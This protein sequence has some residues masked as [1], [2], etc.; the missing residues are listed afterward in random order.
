MMA[1]NHS[2]LVF[3]LVFG[4]AGSVSADEFHWTNN[5]TDSNSWCNRFNWDPNAN[6][7]GTSDTAV[8][9]NPHRGPIVDCDAAVGSI[10]GPS[11]NQVMDVISGTLSTV[12]DWDLQDG[13][14]TINITGSSVVT[15][16]ASM[17]QKN[18]TVILNISGNPTI[19][20]GG[21]M[22]TGNDGGDRFEIH[23]SGGSMDV[24]GEMF[25]GEDG[26]GELDVS[27]GAAFSCGTLKYEGRAGAPW[28]LNL[29]EGTI[30]VRGQFTAPVDSAGA[31]KVTINLDAGILE[32]DSFNSS[33]YAYAM[34]INEGMFVLSGDETV[35]MNADVTAGYIT[36]FNGTEDVL[37]T[38]DAGSDKTTV[39]AD[40]V[41]VKA[42]QPSPD[43]YAQN[44]CPG[45]ELSWTASTNA[46]ATQGHDVYFGTS[47]DD[48]T[49]ATTTAGLGVYKGRQDSTVY[50]ETGI[51]TL[52]L[53]TTYY[54]RIDETDGVDI[55][56]G[57]VWQFTTGDGTAFEPYPA[58]K[59]TAVARNVQLLWTAGCSAISHDVYFATDFNDVNDATT[60]TAGVFVQNQP[61][62]TYSPGALDI[63]TVYY[64]RIDEVT[65]STKHKGNVWSF[66]TV[67]AIVDEHM[68]LWY[69]LDETA[70]SIV[71]DSSGYEHHGSGYRIED[72]W[73]PNNGHIG[74]CLDFDADQNVLVPSDTLDLVTDAITLAVWLKGASGQDED[75]DMVVFDTGDDDNR[76]RATV[77]TDA[78]GLDVY[79]RAGNEANDLL[80]WEDAT[81]SSWR[82]EWH[83]FAFVK[84]ET[85]GSMKIYFDGIMAQ[86]RIGAISSLTNV[87]NKIFK[88]GA[89]A[90][91]SSDYDGKVDDFRIYDRALSDAEIAGLFIGGDIQQPWGPKPFNRETEV[92]RDTILSWRSGQGI[93]FHDVYFGTDLDAVTDAN[94]VVHLEVYKGRQNLDANSYDPAGL[95]LGTTYYWRID[96]VNDADANSPWGRIWTFTV[97]NYIIIDDFESYNDSDNLIYDTW[98]EDTGAVLD[99]FYAG[100]PTHSGEQS[101]WFLYYNDYGP[102]SD[103]S[104]VG[105]DLSGMDF[106]QA[107][108]KALTVFFYGN[109][110]NDA[111]S[112]EEP[113]MGIDDGSTYAESHYTDTNSVE[114]PHLISDIQEEEW[115]EWNVP[116]SDLNTVTLTSVQHIYIGFGQRGSSVEGGYGEVYFDDVRLYPPRCRPEPGLHPV[117]DWS[118]NCIVDY[119]DIGIMADNWLRTD[120]NLSP[121]TNPGTT[122]LVGCW[123]LDDGSGSI[124]TDSSVYANHG[125]LTGNYSWVSGHE[126]S[127]VNF[128]S[129][130]ILVPDALQLRPTSQVSASAWLYYTGN[131][132]KN[133]RV[134]VK[135]RDNFEAYCI[136][137]SDKDSFSFY[138]GEPNGT[139]HFAD[140]NDG[141]IHGDEWSHVAG[142]YD[143]TTVKSYINGQVVGSV[144]AIGLSLSQDANGLGIANRSD[145]MDKPFKG[146]VDE[147]RVYN[148][149][150]TD[151]EVAWLATDGTGYAALRS[152]ANIYDAE[153]QG[154]QVINFRD[155]AKFMTAWMEEK[156]W[157]E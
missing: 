58:D 21:T 93:L 28:S 131:P 7:P 60:A 45:L 122:G 151:A 11:N 3:V 77:P 50:P 25:W 126:N 133:A 143:G 109:P 149:A 14:S 69:E 37:V 80:L 125:A 2:L 129:G 68:V 108:V 145:A 155:F 98:L 115:H 106:T 100:D 127:A 16:G 10:D 146:T 91:S 89:K 102:D 32:C 150:L 24:G 97:A 19:T 15:V 85:A 56:T 17:P 34:D 87:K 104:E 86:S 134:L 79:W 95:E 147:V 88:L 99:D 130:R 29:D 67:S 41:Q 31:G 116:I 139:R 119:A 144:S 120:A 38:Y 13:S 132:G 75:D 72:Q 121:V 136:E 137:Q 66:R 153:G 33:G 90:N 61:G 1:K 76:L 124:A 92:T 112:T 81:P 71:S 42:S 47:L 156:F 70:G 63:L 55:W 78:P 57:D 105:R 152:C 140:S 43:N 8:L 103:Y 30:T 20:V 54:W 26:T 35:A 135:G 44:E 110:T 52:E 36:A 6:V 46:A 142:T 118:G 117:Y 107:G 53:A 94:T 154:A 101:M 39:K 138:V 48:V 82:E 22:K 4:L 12:G 96:E 74:G 65:D 111:G 5:A 9:R 157:P 23:M 84:D 51:L 18:G 83:H 49:N 62:N 141:D 73:E 114:N 27:G 123:K 113:Y 148:R 128:S 59:Q 40:F 64:W